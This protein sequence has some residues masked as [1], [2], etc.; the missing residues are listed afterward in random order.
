MEGRGAGNIAQTRRAVGVRLAPMGSD[1]VGGRHVWGI[2]GE[3]KDQGMGVRN[4]GGC[5]VLL[6]GSWTV[7]CTGR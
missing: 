2:V 3:G 5:V 6:R 7:K 4:R 1:G